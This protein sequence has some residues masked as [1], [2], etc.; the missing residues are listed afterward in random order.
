MVLVGL[1]AKFSEQ[2]KFDREKGYHPIRITFEDK[3]Q[4]FRKN[5]IED[6]PSDRV[7]VGFSD[8]DDLDAEGKYNHELYQN[9][10]IIHIASSSSEDS[11][12]SSE[13]EDAPNYEDGPLMDF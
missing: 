12:Q 2:A 10:N 11:S 8:E 6:W 9:R 13:D 7:P 5:N 3:N 4:N 1:P